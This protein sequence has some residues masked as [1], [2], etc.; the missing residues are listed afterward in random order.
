MF[1]NYRELDG[2]RM[3]SEELVGEMMKPRIRL[4]HEPFISKG[5]I[6]Y[7]YGLGIRPGFF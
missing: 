4:S 6:Y 2:K 5:P 3:I 7:G 1:L